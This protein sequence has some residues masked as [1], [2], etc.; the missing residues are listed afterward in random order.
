MI[1]ILLSNRIKMLVLSTVGA[2]S[3]FVGG[4]AQASAATVTAQAGD[5]VSKIANENG[6]SITA[7]EQ[8]NGINANTHM[9]FAGHT[10]TL[11][12]GAQQQTTAT[13]PAAQTTQTAPQAQQ[14]TTNTQQASQAATAQ[15]AAQQTQTTQAA[16]TQQSTQQSQAAASQQQTQAATTNSNNA[17]SSDEAAKAWIAN[18][19]SGGSYSANN[20]QYV[21]KYQL[22][23]SYLNGDYSASNQ[24]KA[25]NNYVTSRYGSWSAAKTFWQTNGWY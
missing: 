8:V 2:A 6:V 7:F 1:F 16:S 19:E 21:G 14:T 15:R 22:S 10:Y 18:K 20:G 4:I 9:I 3:L 24:E 25:A 12:G 5:T 17:S 11:P 23:A 13:Q